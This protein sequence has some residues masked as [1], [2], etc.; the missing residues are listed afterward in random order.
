M[1]RKPHQFHIFDSEINTLGWYLGKDRCYQSL[2]ADGNWR[3]NI[4]L[5]IRRRFFVLVV[6]IKRK[7]IGGHR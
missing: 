6:L 5:S 4:K 3:Q 2:R 7:D 1:G